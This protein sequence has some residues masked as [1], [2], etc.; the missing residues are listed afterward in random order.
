MRQE[1]PSA[2]RTG[3]WVQTYSRHEDA[4]QYISAQFSDIGRIRKALAERKSS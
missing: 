2:E 3:N 1:V 4:L